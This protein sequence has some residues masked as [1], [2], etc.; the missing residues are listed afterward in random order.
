MNLWTAKDWRA[1]TALAAS[2]VFAGALMLMAWLLINKFDGQAERLITELVRDRQVR[3]EVGA[4]LITIVNALAWGLKLLLAGVI[5][6]ILTLGLAINHRSIKLTKQGL[7]VS[8]GDPDPAA[9]AAQDV[10]GAAE[11]KAAEIVAGANSGEL[12]EK[13]R[14]P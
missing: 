4:V 6:V 13:D 10:A 9:K 1:M 12:P 7:D 11:Q 8:G 14:I 2:V 5:A 3:N